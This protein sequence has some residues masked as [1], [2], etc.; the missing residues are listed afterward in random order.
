MKV[1]NIILVIFLGMLIGSCKKVL[2]KNP[3]DSLTPQQAFATEQNLQLYT[4]SFYQ[5]V[6]SAQA[7]Y[8]ESGSLEGY[9]F[10]GNIISDN[11]GWTQ[12]NP[13]LGNGFTSRNSQ[14]WSWSALRNINY[15]LAH[16]QEAKTTDERKNMYAGIARFFRAWFYYD[17]VKMFGD[18][19][20]YG[21]VINSSD[22]ASLYKA[23]D[24]RTLVMDSVVADL[25]FAI[26]HLSATKDNSSSMITKWTALAL[27]S[28]ICLFEGT[29]RKYHTELNL[30]SS[31]DKFLQQAADAAKQVMDG[32]LYKLRNTGNSRGDYRSLFISSSPVNDE[33]ILARLYS[34]NL[35]VWHSATGFFSDF[36]K[37]QTFL[38]KRFVN[39][40]LN[41]DG[42][43]FTDNPDYN[44]TSFTD[45]IKDRDGRLAQTIRTPGYARSNGLAAPPNLG[46]A[47]TGY[48]V[49]KYSLDDPIYDLN[50]QCYNAIPVIRYAEVLLN[51][52]EAKAELGTFTSNDWDISIALLRK[53]AGITNTAMPTTMDTYMQDNYYPEISSIAIMEIRRERAIEL[54]EEGFRYDDLRRWKKG[55]LLEKPKDGIYVAQLNQLMDLNEDGTPDVYFYTTTAP[56]PQVPGVYYYKIDGTAIKLSDVDKGRILW[57]ANIVKSYPDYKYFGPLPYNELVINKKLVQNEGW[58]HP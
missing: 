25:D 10:Q 14:G 19:P 45:E 18:V 54:V 41:K 1:Y 34:N 30:G 16:Y 17:K 38:V 46:A 35:K 48:Q 50:G 49:L 42:S 39:T 6:P 36:G 23:R 32:G 9:Y 51:Y 21:A 13:Y 29:F 43:R 44:N 37:Y 27:K 40:Y 5:M 55:N 31:A 58:D 52:A 7:I 20:W 57:Q 47:R 33:V 4:N 15:F 56:S 11:T 2:E 53:R 26:A 12:T 24:P 3:L 28:R 8:G 22:S